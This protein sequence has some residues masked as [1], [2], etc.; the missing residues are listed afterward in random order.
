MSTELDEEVLHSYMKVILSKTNFK[1]VLIYAPGS[2]I[3]ERCYCSNSHSDVP[4][5]AQRNVS[6]VAHTLH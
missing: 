6:I 5:A 1:I 2:Y 3:F 4:Q